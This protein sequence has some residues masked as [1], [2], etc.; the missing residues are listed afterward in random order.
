MGWGEAHDRGTGT[1]EQ[2]EEAHRLLDEYGTPPG[3]LGE[4]IA[5]AIEDIKAKI[6][7]VVLAFDGSFPP[8]AATKEEFTERMTEVLESEKVLCTRVDPKSWA[9]VIC[10]T[11]IHS[12]GQGCPC[13]TYREKDFKL[14]SLCAHCVGVYDRLVENEELVAIMKQMLRMYYYYGTGTFAEWLGT[15]YGHKSTEA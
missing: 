9:C 10:S 5:A 8:P 3:S 2:I 11:K 7:P 6:T 12:G 14:N 4:R 1:T 13:A 15:S